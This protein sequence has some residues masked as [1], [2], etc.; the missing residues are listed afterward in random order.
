MRIHFNKDN[1]N[2][3]I[4][5]ETINGKQAELIFKSKV[6]GLTIRRDLKWNS[7]IDNTVKKASKRL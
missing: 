1:V 7:H 5:P 4:R 2:Q 6:L 3:Q